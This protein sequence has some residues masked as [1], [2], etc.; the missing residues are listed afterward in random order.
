LR[1]RRARRLKISRALQAQK[2]LQRRVQQDPK[3]KQSKEREGKREG[4][5]Q[6]KTRQNEAKISN[7]KSFKSPDKTTTKFRSNTNNTNTK[8]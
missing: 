3:K 2:K 5:K 4:K 6:G 1:S 7:R 8:E